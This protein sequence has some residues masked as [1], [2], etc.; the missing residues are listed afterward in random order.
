MKQNRTKIT[1]QF[2]AGGLTEATCTSPYDYEGWCKHIV[3]VALASIRKPET[4][5]QRLGLNELLDRSSKRIFKRLQSSFDR[6]NK[7]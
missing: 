5:Q 1:I 2:D 4:I 6:I 7:G 3:A